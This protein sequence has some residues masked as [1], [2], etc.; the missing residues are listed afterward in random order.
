VTTITLKDGR[1][2]NTVTKMIEEDISPDA[3]DVSGD[4]PIPAPKGNPRLEDLPAPPK[5]MNA[6]VA[7]VGY[8]LLGLPDRDIAYALGCSAEQLNDIL[9]GEIY[10]TTYDKTIEAFV[11][12]QQQSAKDILANGAMM[13]AKEVIK[14]AKHSKNEANRLKAAESVLNRNNIIGEESNSMSSGLTIKIIRDSK[15]ED[16]T[17]SM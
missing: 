10:K 3:D 1:K 11:N 12:G 4:L 8:K 6:T 16:I 17:I 5:V 15:S 13:A 2:L 9:N 7:V 14:I